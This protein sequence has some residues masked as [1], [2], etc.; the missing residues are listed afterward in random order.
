MHSRLFNEREY[1]LGEAQWMSSRAFRHR[2]NVRA[3]HPF[4]LLAKN[5]KGCVEVC[6]QM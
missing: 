3:T 2:Q 4:L 6:D 5:V 1:H